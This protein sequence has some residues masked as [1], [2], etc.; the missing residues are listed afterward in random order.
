MQPELRSISF[1]QRLAPQLSIN[2]DFQTTCSIG[3]SNDILQYLS[4]SMNKDSYFYLP[5]FLEKSETEP[6]RDAILTL[7]KEGL[8]PVFVYIYDQPWSLFDRLCPIIQLFLG[9]R[10]S[11]LPNFW[12]WHIPPIKGSSGW[13]AHTD[14]NVTTRF[15]NIDSGTTLMSM[16]LW[17][18]I[19]D[20]TMEN[21]CMAVLPR[22][23]EVLYDPT[24]TDPRQIRPDDAVNLP[25]KSG[26][27]L[28]WSQDLYHW[29]RYVTSSATT[30]R[31]SLS[32]EF[33]NPVFSPLGHSLL[34]IKQPPS[35]KERLALILSQFDKY[36]DMENTN[37]KINLK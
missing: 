29:S 24:I 23:R 27:V 16:S 31:I 2:D 12:A 25:A 3:I 35:F 26:S 33:Q 11:L 14:C 32:L 17:V 6:I 1:W 36:K 19:T 7:I 13:S 4:R 8:P 5:P 18:P 22:S 28:G 10:F 9:N 21:G 30:P 34:D 15:E 20:A 37:F